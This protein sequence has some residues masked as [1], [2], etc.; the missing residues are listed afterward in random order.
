M[1]ILKDLLTSISSSPISNGI[2]PEKIVVGLDNKIQKVSNIYQLIY[3][4]FLYS[5][6]GFFANLLAR[7]LKF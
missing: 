1:N 5:I 7:F 4:L 6:I 2:R 3:K